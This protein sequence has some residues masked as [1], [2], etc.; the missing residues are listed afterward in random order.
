MRKR[1]LAALLL[2]VSGTHAADPSSGFHSRRY[3]LEPSDRIELTYRYTPEYN[4]S[5]TI[6]PDGVV[7]IKLIGDVSIAG[8][9]LDEARTVVIQQLKSRLNDPEVTI[10]IQDFVRPSYTVVGLVGSPGRYEMHGRL[11]ALEAIATAGGFKDTAKHSQVILYRRVSPDMAKTHVLNLK[12]LMDPK[13][14]GEEESIEIEPGD[15]LVV[16]KNRISKIA[17]YV[18]WVSFGSYI[19][20]S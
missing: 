4:E 20:L 16:P 8:L 7:S 3:R 6:Q 5:L 2:M 17:D 10:T 1:V 12:K 11:S 15:M 19:P 18:H 9:T 13:H 14:A